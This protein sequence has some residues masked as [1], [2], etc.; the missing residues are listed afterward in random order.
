[1]PT[2]TSRQLAWQTRSLKC[3]FIDFGIDYLY[4]ILSLVAVVFQFGIARKLAVL[5]YKLHFVPRVIK[6]SEAGNN[7]QQQQAV[8]LVSQKVSQILK[9]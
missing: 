7:K 4:L 1:M 8:A 6:C 9:E 3:L 2:G 5:H